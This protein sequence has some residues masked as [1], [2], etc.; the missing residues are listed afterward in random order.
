MHTIVLRD[1][2]TPCTC[3]QMGID[4]ELGSIPGIVWSDS[5]MALWQ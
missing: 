5:R 4:D 3:A 2:C 1:M